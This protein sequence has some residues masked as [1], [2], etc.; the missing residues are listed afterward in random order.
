MDFVYEA[1]GNRIPLRRRTDEPHHARLL[2]LG[3]ASG[4][5]WPP[6]DLGIPP[7]H[8]GIAWRLACALLGRQTFRHKTQKTTFTI[9][10][11]LIVFLHVALVVAALSFF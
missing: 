1:L 8:A 10:T 7:A 4:T 11:W 3:Q 2:W 6:A 9:K 5:T